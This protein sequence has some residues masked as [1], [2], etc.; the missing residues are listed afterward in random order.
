MTLIKN[1]N[2]E[3]EAARK[4]ANNII[5]I[6]DSK[7]ECVSN[8][9]S[10]NL[11][12]RNKWIIRVDVNEPLKYKCECPSYNSSLNNINGT[13][14]EKWRNPP[15]QCKHVLAVMINE[16]INP[17]IYNYRIFDNTFDKTFN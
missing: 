11:T 14:L 4:I 6:N 7:W 13:I 9:R 3:Y 5:K 12:N 16:N 10:A 15:K 1:F 17:L 8:S 2:K